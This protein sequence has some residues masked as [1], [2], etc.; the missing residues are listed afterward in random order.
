[1]S[2]AVTINAPG[3]EECAERNEGWSCCIH[4]CIGSNPRKALKLPWWAPG[5]SQRDH[6][7]QVVACAA[8]ATEEVSLRPMAL[9]PGGGGKAANPFAAFG[10]GAGASLVKK[11]ISA[12][13]GRC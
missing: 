7:L 4:I 3:W 2:V 12:A 9:R 13:P 10:K 8:M 1:V 11:V 5:G 6:F